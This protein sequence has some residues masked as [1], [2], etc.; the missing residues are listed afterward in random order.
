[1]GASQSSQASQKPDHVVSAPAGTSVEVSLQHG[2]DLRANGTVVSH[3]VAINTATTRPAESLELC[4][5]LLYAD[6][7]SPRR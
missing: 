7:S 5:A 6:N 1:M 4:A 3:H 2:I